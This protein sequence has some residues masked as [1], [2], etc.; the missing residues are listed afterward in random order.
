VSKFL[1]FDFEGQPIKHS[2][3][4]MEYI[5][6]TLLP[7]VDRTYFPFNYFKID[8]YLYGLLGAQLVARNNLKS[9][10]SV[11]IVGHT[12]NMYFNPTYYRT[13]IEKQKHGFQRLMI[14]K[15]TPFCRQGEK[16]YLASKG[17]KE[18]SKNGPGEARAKIIRQGV[19]DRCSEAVDGG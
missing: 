6:I 16:P 18:S 5:F 14:V 1:H 4:R 17:R 9:D 13:Y 3:E 12:E 2:N 15:C 11:L 8:A 10:I 19:Q 7:N